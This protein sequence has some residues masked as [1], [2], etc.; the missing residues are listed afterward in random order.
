MIGFTSAVAAFGA[1]FI[2]K[3]FGSSIAATGGPELA[4]YGFIGF[5]VSCVVVTW[6]YYTRRNAEVRL[7]GGPADAPRPTGASVA[8]ASRQSFSRRARAS[9]YFTRLPE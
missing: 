2:P 4:L 5:Y 9:G 1:F 6:W 7:T 8:R 3:T